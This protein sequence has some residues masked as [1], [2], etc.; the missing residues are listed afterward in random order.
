MKAVQFSKYGGPEVLQV[1]EVE[2]PHAG[3]GQVRIAVRAAGVNPSDWK[4]RAGDARD[5]E[6]VPL[7]SGVGF[8]ASGVVDEVGAGVSNVA[9]GDA[10]FGYGAS[11]VAEYAVLSHWAQKPDNVSFDV[12]GGLPVIAE[13]A[14]RC[15]EQLGVQA[16][17][18]LLVSGASGGIGSA[19]VQLASLRGITVIGTASATKHEYLRELGAIPTT[20]GPGL[21]ERVRQLAPKGVDRAL[22]VAG[23]GIIPEL[24][25][26]VHDPARVL[27]VADLSAPQYGAKFCYGPPKNSEQVFAKLARLCSEGRFRLHVEQ[28]FPLER[29][30]EA[31]ELS[32]KGHV[33][34]KLI[35]SVA[36][37]EEN[38][39]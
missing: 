31:Q 28:T 39:Q 17:E 22:D 5:S 11:A 25:E 12:A 34:G 33:T 1:V 15:L 36:Q 23:S 26:I 37:L 20:Y 3:T 35:I 16:G 27:S 9:V 19:V 30:A 32:A 7:P 10:V 14:S 4:D 38:Q 18:T 24:I 21:E 29:T 6:P 8:E 13:T 2:E